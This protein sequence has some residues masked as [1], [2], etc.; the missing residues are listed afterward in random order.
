MKTQEKI[1][2]PFVIASILI[3][4]L[5][6]ANTLIQ[7]IKGGQISAKPGS[8]NTRIM[9]IENGD[10]RFMNKGNDDDIVGDYFS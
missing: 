1:F 4:S 7:N 10:L 8:Y 2:S 9:T 5:Y 6:A 3:P